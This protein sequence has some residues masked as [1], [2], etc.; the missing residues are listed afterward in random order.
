[1]DPM[2]MFHAI[3]EREAE[4]E[5]G[6]GVQMQDGTGEEALGDWRALR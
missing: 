6:L 1:V 4:G 5:R 2:P 3:G